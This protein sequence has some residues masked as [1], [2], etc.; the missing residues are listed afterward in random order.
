MNCMLKVWQE[1][2][3]RQT[4]TISYILVNT[5]MLGANN[6]Y[7]V[8]TPAPQATVHRK[9]NVYL[10]TTYITS[11]RCFSIP[12]RFQYIVMLLTGY[13]SEGGK[14]KS[15]VVRSSVQYKKKCGKA[16]GIP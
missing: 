16:S 6:S 3:V 14:K 15:S 1:E 5:Y 13:F 12:N 10:G 2:G 7:P 9:D 11:L 8:C 4:G